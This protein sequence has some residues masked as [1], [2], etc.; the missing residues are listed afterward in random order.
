MRK[1]SSLLYG[2]EDTPPLL[3]TVSNSAQHVAVIAINF[4][5]LTAAASLQKSQEVGNVEL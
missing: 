3:I 5:Y 4:I 1:P 2:V